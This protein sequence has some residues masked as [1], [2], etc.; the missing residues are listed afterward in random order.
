MRL[1]MFIAAIFFSL[2]A[3]AQSDTVFKQRVQR[4]LSEYSKDFRG[5]IGKQKLSGVPKRLFIEPGLQGGIDE[6]HIWGDTIFIYSCVIQESAY[7]SSTRKRLTRLDEQLQNAL[8]SQFT[9]KAGMLSFSQGQEMP[10]N[11]K[12][13]NIEVYVMV[14]KFKENMYMTLLGFKGHTQ[15]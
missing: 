6:L 12:S 9:R 15:K 3:F 2:I 7:S 10:L 4:V 1:R 5:F 11:F 13:S 14:G 8:G